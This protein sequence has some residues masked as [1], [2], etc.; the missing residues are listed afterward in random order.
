MTPSISKNIKKM[1]R[2]PDKNHRPVHPSILSAIERIKADRY[3][4]WGGNGGGYER[5]K[6]IYVKKFKNKPFNFILE[7][8]KIKN[9]NIMVIGAGKG[10]DLLFFKKELFD[11]GVKTNID[12]LSLSKAL[13]P[14]ILDK[15][16]IRNDFSPSIENAKALDKYNILENKKTLKQVIGKY[17]LLINEKGSGAFTKYPHFALFQSALFLSQ[18]GRAF[19][20][21]EV[22]RD[23]N[24]TLNITKRL[25]TAYNKKHN[26]SL[27]FKLSALKDTLEKFPNSKTIVIQIDRVK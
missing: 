1:K 24:T 11:F 8:L 20:E 4:S 22:Q 17:H 5:Y 6:E 27:E 23:V 2:N 15:K 16:I 10:Q 7:E 14:V 3:E 18:K 9:P 26:L 19:V 13:D 12:V 25:I 21:I